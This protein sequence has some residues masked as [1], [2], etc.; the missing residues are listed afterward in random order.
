MSAIPFSVASAPLAS[1]LRQLAS[2][3]GPLVGKRLRDRRRR[4]EASAEKT[5]DEVLAEVAASL[6]WSGPGRVEEVGLYLLSGTA[7]TIF[8][9]LLTLQISSGGNEPSFQSLRQEFVESLAQFL[10]CP[11]SEVAGPGSALFDSVVASCLEALRNAAADG[12]LPALESL[13]S[14]RHRFLLDEIDALHRKLELVSETSIDTKA[15]EDYERDLRTQLEDRFKTLSPPSFAGV[16]RVPIQDIYVKQ[17][18]L[19]RRAHSAKAKL[20]NFLADL[21]ESVRRAKFAHTVPEDD[22]LARL[23]R[24]VILGNPGGGKSTFAAKV[25]YDLASG[26]E[27]RRCSG[28]Q[29]TPFVIVL[30]DYGSARRSRPISFVD[31]MAEVSNGDYNIPAP[32]GA[33]E[34]LLAS[35][36][37]LVIF[38]GL[39]E[40]LDNEARLAIA[41]A[42]ESFATRYSSTPILV[43]SRSVG[44]EQAPLDNRFEVYE[45]GAFDDDQVKDYVQRWFSV[46]AQQPHRI[47]KSL[48]SA[49][50]AE[51]TTVGDL[52]SNPLML[53]LMCNIYRG[54]GYIPKNR[55]DVYEKCATMLFERWDKSRGLKHQLAFESSIDAGMKHLAHWIYTTPDL[56]SGVAE[57]ALID[58]ATSYFRERRYEEEDEAR[59]AAKEFIE[60]CSGR[61]WVFTDTGLTSRGERLFQ[62]THRTFLEYFTAAHL[63]RTY[64]TTRQLYKELEPHISH[65][66]WDVVAQLAFQLKHKAT[67]GAID[68]LLRLLISRARSAALGSGTNM[69]YFAT[70]CLEFLVPSPRTVRQVVGLVLA[71]CI[72]ADNAEAGGEGFFGDDLLF[73]VK[74]VAE[75]NRAAAAKEVEKSMSKVFSSESESVVALAW[76]VCSEILGQR[77]IPWSSSEDDAFWL[78]V[79]SGILAANSDRVQRLRESDPYVAVAAFRNRQVSFKS[80]FN[81]MGPRIFLPVESR[82][83]VFLP[84][85]APFWELV[86]GILNAT[87]D[88]SDSSQ[89]RE[90]LMALRRPW[91]SAV[92]TARSDAGL[93]EARP[94]ANLE[95]LTS[96]ELFVI[97]AG[98]ALCMELEVDFLPL[99]KPKP[100]ASAELASRSDTLGPKGRALDLI[101]SVRAQGDVTALPDL[102]PLGW[103]PSVEVFAGAWALRNFSL[104]R[105]KPNSVIE[106]TG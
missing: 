71:L 40:L 31:F 9:H 2:K 64:Q 7:E 54:Q 42:V 23:R 56:Q 36:R 18:F 46:E 93:R 22:L 47:A 45:I 83:A 70:R 65:R 15:I 19:P 72:D 69:V 66:E 97:F 88:P 34:Y 60:F 55:P 87:G 12:A 61:A 8:R 4:R 81:L 73:S 49:F 99:G 86:T 48:A 91:V 17:G 98:A 53:A 32:F 59:S 75:E 92:A 27:D 28:R 95:A 96:D 50:L 39:D 20:G 37:M 76:E 26:Y 13:D 67:E 85:R 33:F 52:R 90:V 51:S 104:L 102:S 41:K 21:E 68:E 82:T 58:R 30:R 57:S 77:T 35:G 1:I 25:C 100:S 10:G 62:F 43:T 44:Y 11:N 103:E 105:R 5:R 38:D 29:L 14:V 101:L 80:V 74:R 16:R 63:V 24:C 106:V 84:P 79:A 6:E 89:A 3:D 78:G 94:L